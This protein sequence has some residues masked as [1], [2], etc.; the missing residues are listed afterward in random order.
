M[1]CLLHIVLLGPVGDGEVAARARLYQ[2]EAAV[3]DDVA[4]A[5]LDVRREVAAVGVQ[6]VVL[7]CVHF[8]KEYKPSTA[9]SMTDRSTA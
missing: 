3:A 6:R 7:A 8:R 9:S 2:I 1:A 4:P 5:F